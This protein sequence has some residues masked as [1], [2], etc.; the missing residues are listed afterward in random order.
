MSFHKMTESLV[1]GIITPC[2][3]CSEENIANILKKSLGIEK[4]NNLINRVL[5]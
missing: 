5:K 4:H 3:A 2:H 1:A